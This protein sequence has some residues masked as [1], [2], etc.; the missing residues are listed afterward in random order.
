MLFNGSRCLGLSPV[1]NLLNVFIILHP[2]DACSLLSLQQQIV[3]G[4]DVVESVSLDLRLSFGWLDV[5]ILLEHG[6]DLGIDRNW[7]LS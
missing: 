4:R 6:C 1:D 5:V 7:L 2:E 3:R